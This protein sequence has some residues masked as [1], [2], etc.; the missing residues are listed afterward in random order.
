MNEP[1]RRGSWIKLAAA[2]LILAALFAAFRLLPVQGYLTA[3]IDF[4]RGLGV[5]GPVLYAGVYV[6][7]TVLMF[8]GSLLTLAAGFIFGLATG[9]VTVSIGSLAGATCAFLV[10]RTFARGFVE[11]QAA[12]HPR[13]AAL[14]R[15]VAQEGFKIVLL[16]RLS[17][18]FPFNLL[19]YLFSLTKVRLRDYVLASWLGML[20]GALLYIYL[21]TAAKSLTEIFSGDFQSLQR[22]GLWPKLLL[23]I[24]L[25][26]TLAVTVLIT[27]IARR[28]LR[29][30]LREED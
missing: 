26:A 8:P 27:R 17:P 22:G 15:A 25:L 2:I 10:G 30:S 7:A 6:V 19:N 12:A 14:D 21:G 28:A 29:R 9:L 18:L 16:T 23:G 4:I 13:F 24:G 3:F 11:Q 5:W 20:P 1:T